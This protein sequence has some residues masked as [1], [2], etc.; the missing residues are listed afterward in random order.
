MIEVYAEKK[1]PEEIC[2][3]PLDEDAEKA[4]KLIQSRFRLRKKKWNLIYVSFPQRKV[5]K[6][7]DQV[8]STSS[9]C[10]EEVFHKFHLRS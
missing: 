9:H 3:I 4:A 10:T 6:H 1:I 5:T 7:C 8:V 2:D